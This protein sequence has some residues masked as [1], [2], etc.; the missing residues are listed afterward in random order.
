MIL[1]L[2]GLSACVANYDSTV[3]SHIVDANIHS[4]NAS[5]IC[6]TTGINQD[7]LRQLSEAAVYADVY[8]GGQPNNGDLHTI[9][10]QLVDEIERFQTV[11]SQGTVSASYCQQKVAN[12]QKIA[13]L[14]LK[15]SGAQPR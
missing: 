10:D 1:S 12:I 2:I 13:Q 5:K 7:Q 4:R 14:A 15:S 11:V 9:L 3:Y 8:A 6:T